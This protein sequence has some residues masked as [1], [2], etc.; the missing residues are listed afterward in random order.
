MRLLTRITFCLFHPKL[1]T[2]CNR[3]LAKT[4]TQ[5]ELGH[6]GL[7]WRFSTSSAPCSLSYMERASAGSMLH[8]FSTLCFLSAERTEFARCNDNDTILSTLMMCKR[9]QRV[10]NRKASLPFSGRA[11]L[12]GELWTWGLFRLRCSSSF[13]ILFGFLKAGL[14]ESTL[15]AWLRVWACLQMFKIRLKSSHEHVNVA[16]FY[17]EDKRQTLLPGGSVKLWAFMVLQ[18]CFIGSTRASD[19]FSLTR[20]HVSLSSG[21][22]ASSSAFV[23]FLS[24]PRAPIS[25]SFSPPGRR[26]EDFAVVESG[27]WVGVD[28][29]EVRRG[30]RTGDT[31]KVWIVKVLKYNAWYILFLFQK[32]MNILVLTLDEHQTTGMVLSW[33]AFLQLR[34]SEKRKS[35]SERKIGD[36]SQRNWLECIPGRLGHEH[37]L[38]YEVCWQVPGRMF[39]LS[40][41]SPPLLL[42]DNNVNK[43]ADS[44]SLT[45]ADKWIRAPPHTLF[46]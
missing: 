33:I 45:S 13:G 29:E 17:V 46:P 41:R 4:T 23:V 19:F 10:N 34:F 12:C 5:K 14:P 2:E 7:T 20:S 42:L 18:V 1:L 3:A 16:I 37:N 30:L 9:Q 40:L 24:L 44:N 36:V 22:F 11:R 32:R 39:L 27:L 28:S 6:S 26:D 8:M 21:P 43:P 25:V 35:K 15:K 38:P 31:K